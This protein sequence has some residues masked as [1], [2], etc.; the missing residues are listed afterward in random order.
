[1][2]NYLGKEKKNKTKNKNVSVL[3]MIKIDR[4][5]IARKKLT[6]FLDSIIFRFEIELIKKLVISSHKVKISLFLPQFDYLFFLI[7]S[8]FDY[9]FVCV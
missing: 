6:D 4:N 3:L 5:I 8:I 2:E 1:M 7:F 9:L